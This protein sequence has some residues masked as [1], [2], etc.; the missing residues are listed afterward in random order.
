MKV[1]ITGPDGVLGNNLVRLLLAE[2]YEVRVFIQTGN[3]AEYLED[4]P[5][6]REY[7]NLLHPEE[8][9][10]AVEGCD[11]IIHAAAK[12]DTWPCRHKS[13][14]DVN[15]EGTRNIISAVKEY[16]IKKLIHIGTANSFGAGDKLDPGTEERPYEGHKYKLD[17][18]SSK[19][20]IQQEIL[21]SVKEDGLNAMILNPTFMI[22]PYDAKPSSGQM[23]IAVSEGKLPGYPGGALPLFRIPRARPFYRGKCG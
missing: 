16:G 1:F 18:I 2:K 20:A 5:I 3:R 23:I 12:T 21:T 10:R 8:V 11:I 9:N 15:V 6:E 19:Y 4:L 7:G 22:G 14:W 17:Y 13:Y